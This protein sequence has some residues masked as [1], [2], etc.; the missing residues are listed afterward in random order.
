MAIEAHP[1][2]YTV[3]DFLRW[4]KDGT[5]DLK[6]PFQ[7]GSVWRAVLKSSLIDSLLRGYPVPALFLQDRTDATTLDRQLVVVDGQQRLRTLIGY[8]DPS[9]LTDYDDRDDFVIQHVHDRT[10]AGARF[11]DLSEA[12]RQLILNSRL[13]VYTVGSS[14]VDRELL[15]IFRRM[16][17][18]GAKLNAQ[19]LRNAEYSGFFKEFVYRFSADTLDRWLAW[20]VFNRQ[21]IAE[22]RDVEFVSDL[23]L[24]VLT[25]RQAV[26]KTTLDHAYGRYEE[27]FDNL[28]AVET[29]LDSFRSDLDE[30]LAG[31]ALS[32]LRS[33][34]WMY[35]L[36]DLLQE[37]RYRGPMSTP[38]TS[39]RHRV[40]LKRLQSR[41]EDAQTA[42]KAG[43]VDN[44]VVSA[45]RGAANDLSSR[46]TRFEF[47]ESYTQ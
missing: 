29:R 28:E 38:A 9:A 10:R 22:M 18:Y 11:A 46:Q 3:L 33:R 43:D 40:D 17:T 30:L 12:D 37:L 25:G 19:E 35:T 16:N 45:T 32:G 5:L 7:R 8:V 2:T 20:G 15:E 23:A 44:S 47:V 4:Q 6:P 24:L 13:N 42:L 31:G 34:M 27:R 41:L 1:T 21:Q 26:S 39:R 14:V 36:V